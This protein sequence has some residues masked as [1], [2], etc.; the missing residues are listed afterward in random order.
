MIPCTLYSFVLLSLT[1]FAAAAP[2]TVEPGALEVG[3]AVT[4]IAETEVVV[5]EFGVEWVQVPDVEEE[6]VERRQEAAS[7]SSA[8]GS[9]SGPG[10]K[11]RQLEVRK[12]W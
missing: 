8:S 3:D 2:Q 12:E 5:D 10:K 11:C 7:T 9:A 4:P 6:P 1:A